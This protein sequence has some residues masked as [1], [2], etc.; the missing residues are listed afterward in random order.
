MSHSTHCSRV[1]PLTFVLPEKCVQNP[2]F[3]LLDERNFKR[4]EEFIPERWTTKPELTVD[5]SVFIPFAYGMFRNPPYRNDS[6]DSPVEEYFRPW[7][8]K[9]DISSLDLRPIQLYW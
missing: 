7:T 4:P 6:S 3:I 2:K 9:A 8:T 1:S 5:S